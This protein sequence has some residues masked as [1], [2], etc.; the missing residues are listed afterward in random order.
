MDIKGL[1]ED[2]IRGNSFTSVVNDPLAQFGQEAAPFLLTDLLPEKEVP[3]NEFVEE[4]I[5]YRTI[6]ANAG[7]RYSPVQIKGGV[8]TGSARVSLGNSDIGSHF[9]GADY[10][11]L[12]KLLARYSGSGGAT[13]PT[14]ESMVN[15]ILDWA[16]LTLNQPLL[17][18]NEVNRAMALFGAQVI[19]TGDNGYREVVNLPNPSGARVAAGGQYSNDAYDP[20]PDIIARVIYLSDKGY[21]VNRI[22]TSGSVLTKLCNN[23]KIRARAGVS[24]IVSGTVVGLPGAVSLA[25]LNEMAVADDLPPF[26]KYDRVYFTQNGYGYVTPRDEI[27]FASLT[28]RDQRVERGD[29]EPVVVNNTL[30]YTAVGRPAG[31]AEPGRVIKVIPKMDSK[32]PHVKGEA[33]QTSF[34]VVTDPEAVA[35]IQ[36]IT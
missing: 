34:P 29:M 1:V 2:M 23:A 12:L 25:R 24:S 13:R 14:M 6:I 26:E 5:R 10:D 7:T 8:I 3:E 32:P 30:G 16:E 4:G 33:W 19:L 15:Q 28:G 27:L 21:K 11:A 22:L 31:Q 20:W 9:T 17:V 18:H 36:D 35:T